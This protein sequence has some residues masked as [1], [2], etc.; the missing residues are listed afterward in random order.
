MKINSRN[1][2][3][4]VAC[5]LIISCGK[6]QSNHNGLLQALTN[7]EMPDV[8]YPDD[9][10]FT[11]DRFE[12][13]KRLFYDTRLSADHKVSCATC[14]QQNLAFAD[15]Q[16]T[17]SGAF[18]RPG[19]RNAP[20]LSNI[21]LHP[22]YT[23]EGGVPTL[24]MQILVPIQEH[25]EFGTN[26]IDLANELS[27]DSTYSILSKKAY[28]REFDAYVLTRALANFERTLISKESKFDRF[29]YNDNPC[30]SEEERLGLELFY[31]DRTGCSNCHSGF[32]F[33]NY[34]IE[35]N[36]LYLN[37][38]DSGRYRL[39]LNH[40]DIGKFK[41]P[42]L[43]NV[44]LTAPYMHDGSLSTLSDVI[45]HYSDNIQSHFNNNLQPLKLNNNEKAALVAFLKT[46]TDEKFINNENFKLN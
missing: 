11:V 32:N 4:I 15:N 9:N 20:S 18:G 43:R 26:I 29:Y 19:V 23:R 42:S 5:L 16:K 2:V 35:N 36:G 40:S 10:K 33:T 21:S 39:T 24:E 31:S 45:D 37:Y 27:M 44:A 22:Y 1:S 6:E 12:L 8:I 13:G 28:N 34:Q 46:L 14:H 25:N 38:A 41:V 30:F 17:T 7:M 3:F